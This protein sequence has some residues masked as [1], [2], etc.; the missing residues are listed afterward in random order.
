MNYLKAIAAA[1]VAGATA[2]VTALDDNTITSAEWLAAVV[3]VCGSAGVVWYV[4][5]GPGG[6]YAKAIF[7]GISTLAAS[8]IVAYNDNMVSTQEWLTAGIA[9][10]VGLGLVAAVPGPSTGNEA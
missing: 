8:L 1:V 9:T 6:Q 4:T 5:N 10:L 7:A 3:A 2:I